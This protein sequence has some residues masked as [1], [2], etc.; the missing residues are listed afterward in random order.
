MTP[1]TRE[2]TSSRTS[3]EQRTSV[4]YKTC[5]RHPNSRKHY[6]YIES[7]EQPVHQPVTLTGECLRCGTT[8]EKKLHSR[9]QSNIVRL[10]DLKTACQR[11]RS[12]YKPIYGECINASLQM[13][14]W[15]HKNGIPAD[16]RRFAISEEPMEV[17]YREEPAVAHHAVLVDSRYLTGT[18]KESQYM[19]IDVTLDQFHEPSSG[20]PRPTPSHFPKLGPKDDIPSIGVFGPDNPELDWYCPL[21]L[22]MGGKT[23]P[24]S[25]TKLFDID[26]HPTHPDC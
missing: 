26:I 23:A 15:C 4:H 7:L 21:P 14:E 22:T 17:N 6:W 20:E 5:S 18:S 12:E 24:L 1:E 13:V 2:T 3:I 10:A 25:K 16:N 9:S 8:L 19:L 11:I